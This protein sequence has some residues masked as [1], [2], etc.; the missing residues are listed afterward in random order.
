MASW[1]SAEST[2]II[3]VHKETEA[4]CDLQDIWN[5]HIFIFTAGQALWQRGLVSGL[6]FFLLF[7]FFF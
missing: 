4:S 3:L 7:F 5:S 2:E 1:N 6:W